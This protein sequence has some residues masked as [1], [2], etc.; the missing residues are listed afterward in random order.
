MNAHE[1][2]E[3][4]AALRR[5]NGDLVLVG[6]TYLDSEYTDAK[7]RAASHQREWRLGT[8]RCVLVCRDVQFGPWRA[9]EVLG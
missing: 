4:G 7:W 8:V 1:A 6:H 3:W 2:I 5:L 9:L